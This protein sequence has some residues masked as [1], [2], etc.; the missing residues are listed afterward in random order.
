MI[1]SSY[2]N[3]HIHEEAML[4][5]TREL[6]SSWP[7]KKYTKVDFSYPSDGPWE[8]GYRCEGDVVRAFPD[9]K[10]GDI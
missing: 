10:R 5:R 1:R 6:I 8:N 4:K 2:K 3:C 9:A 7:I